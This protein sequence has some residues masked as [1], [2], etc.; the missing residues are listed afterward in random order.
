MPG[1]REVQ[2]AFAA[3]VLDDPDTAFSTL[4]MDGPYPGARLLQV[5]RNNVHTS[6]T[7]ALQAVYPVV[8]LLVGTAFLAYAADSYLRRYPSRSGNLHDFGREFAEFLHTFPAAMALAYLPQ[9]A[10]LEWA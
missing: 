6:L 2:Q 10:Q 1:L 7:G 4:L 8:T 9:V 3:A 5:Y